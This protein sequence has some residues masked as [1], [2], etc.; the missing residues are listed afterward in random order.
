MLDLNP[1]EVIFVRK[2]KQHERSTIFQVT[3]RGK[4][5]VMK[6]V[7]EDY[8]YSPFEAGHRCRTIYIHIY[9]IELAQNPML[10]IPLST[11][12]FSSVRAQPN[13]D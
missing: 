7:S 1:S 13:A 12:I 2:I 5:C 8:H 10:K 9:S 11:T 6:V 4:E 3:V